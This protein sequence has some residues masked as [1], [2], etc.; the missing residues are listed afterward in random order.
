MAVAVSATI[1]VLINRCWLRSSLRTPNP[2][3]AGI[4]KSR[5]IRSGWV[6]RALAHGLCPVDRLPYRMAAFLQNGSDEFATSRCIVC[7][8]NLPGASPS[9]PAVMLKNQV[10]A[11]TVRK[12]T[13]FFGIANQL[14]IP[15]PGKSR[16]SFLDEIVNVCEMLG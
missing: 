8:K 9:G 12:S 14:W 4:C 1:G 2:S 15:A 16:Q 11:Y 13:E 7:N 3:S 6:S 10:A 5:T